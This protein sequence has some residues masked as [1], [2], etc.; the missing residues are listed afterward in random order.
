M[1]RNEIVILVTF[2]ARL[3]LQ[4][5]VLCIP[6]GGGTRTRASRESSNAASRHQ[7]VCFARPRGAA[8]VSS[9]VFHHRSPL[10]GDLPLRLALQ[11]IIARGREKDNKQTSNSAPSLL[12]CVS[13]TSFSQFWCLLCS[14]IF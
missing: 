13:S 10:P 6:E 11:K 2:A 14:L 9:R 12:R 7:A 5:A 1:N 4:A 3:V 8:S